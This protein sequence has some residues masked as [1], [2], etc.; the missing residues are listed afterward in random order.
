VEPISGGLASRLEARAASFVKD[1]RL[2]GAAV[3]IVHGEALTWSA[4]V[5]FADVESRRVPEP[6][7]LYRVASITKTFTGTAIMRLRDEGKLALDDPIGKH[8][9][10][11]AHLEGVTIRRLLAHESG[12]QSEP[13]D[14][15]WRRVVY[16]GSIAK[17]LARATEIKTKVPPNTQR[18]YSNMGFQ[19]LGEVVARRTGAA[20]V[21]HVRKTILEP[22]GMKHSTFDPR[23]EALATGY[24]GRFVSDELE[25]ASIP[26]AVYA[27]GGLCS[28]VDDLARWIAYQFR[29]DPTLREMHQPRYLTDETWTQASGLA[30]YAIRRHDVVWIQ[31][32]GGLHGF[33]SNICFDATHRVG[34]IAL[35]NGIGDAATLAMDLGE[36][37]REAVVAVPPHV[38]APE[39]TPER[40]RSLLGVYFASELGLTRRVE[41]RNGKL[42]MLA[43]DL[44]E[45]HPTL[46]PTDDPDVF[47][48][49]PGFRESGENAVFNRLPDGRVAS[50]F[51]AA[52]TWTRLEP[53][54]SPA[55][56][57]RR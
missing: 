33:S 30:W 20:Y 17:N 2:P 24:A 51:I 53:V 45:W 13:P 54:E 46:A 6:V 40:Y 5:G 7:T 8:I 10:E 25:H 57:E 31:H 19:L 44:P 28:C 1:N 16:E 26:P 52:G 36:I 29:D 42:T 18:K 12:L 35:I 4:G 48:I 43:P 22:L 49:E 41:W 21:D 34:A 47:V 37:A 32:S 3:G 50:V 27:E 11:V 9:P 15:D 14:T 23:P 38:A 56:V 55:R 39:P